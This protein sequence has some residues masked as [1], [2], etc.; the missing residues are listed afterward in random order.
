M[1][2]LQTSTATLTRSR[3]VPATKLASEAHSTT[4]Y[5]RLR[6]LIIRGNLP[7]SVRLIEL[8]VANRL[9]ISRTPA[10]EAI[11]RLHQ[12]G[13]LVAV[14][15]GPRTQFAVA[16]L[17]IDD[18]LDLYSIMAGLEGTAARNAPKLPSSERRV[19]A[20]RLKDA[21]DR[22]VALGKQR[23]HDF[24]QLFELHNAFHDEL[25]AAAASPRLRDLIDR[26]R[27][28]V[29]RYEYVYAP[30]VGPDYEDTF[31]EHVAIIR[32]VRDGTPAAAESAMRANWINS[33]ERL[34]AAMNR[35]GPRGAW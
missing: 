35:S 31:A 17:T 8:D 27:P 1:A 21:N 10:R 2:I 23:N 25:V 34:Q 13:F 6:N 12:D 22:F 14:R 30:T 5:E 20:K 11:Q 7:P 18:M 4:A 19:L 29:Q 15:A 26:V 33:G 32:A 9:G 24:D 16:P 28:Q 3:M